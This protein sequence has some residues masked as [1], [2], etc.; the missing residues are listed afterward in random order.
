MR[1]RAVRTRKPCW[2]RN[3]SITSS[4]VPRSSPTAA[5]RL[6]MPTGP[7][8][9]CSM[10]AAGACGRAC[11]SPERRP[12]ADRAPRPRPARRCGRRLAP[13]HSRA[14]GAAAGWRCAACRASAARCG[15][16]PPASIG[17]PSIAAERSTMRLEILDAVELEPLHDAE[18]VAQRRG[19]QPG[20]RRR[21]DQR[22][23]REVE[24]DRARR[25]ALADHDVELVVLHRRIQH[26]LDHR[27]EAMDLVDEQHI[28]RLQIGEDRREIAGPLEH[29]ARGLAQVDA[30]LGGDDVRQR[31]LAEARRAEDQARD[32]AP[33]RACAAALMKISSCVLTGV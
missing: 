29:R 23:G 18:A 26:L 19:Q 6:S 3:G 28:A 13:G 30:E 2:M 11:R 22:E 4:S 27:R 1:P 17:T 7:P 12:R 25:R 21:A 24:L 20:A 16:A 32:R 9:K 5:A 8:S 33:R 31:R 15:C 10:I 14:P